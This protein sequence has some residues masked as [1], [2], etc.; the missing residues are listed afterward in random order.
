MRRITSFQDV[1]VANK[2]LSDQVTTLKNQLF[3][4][5][6]QLQDTS[7]Q[8]QSVT[9]S[10]L[11]TATTND[12]VFTWA[13]GTTKISWPGGSLKDT[14]QKAHVIPAGNLTLVASTYY[15]MVW[16]K[17]H[18]KVVAVTSVDDPIYSNKDNYVICQIFT[19][20][21]AQ[22]GVAGGGGSTSSRDLSGARYKNF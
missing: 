18:Q 14:E 12:M 22:S 21:G 9:Q 10:N 7:T 20:A 16:N 8:F 1:A 2:E 5:V 3:D 15:W 13:G 11:R 17:A 19:G 4:A 6:K